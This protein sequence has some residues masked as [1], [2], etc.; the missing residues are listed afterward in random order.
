MM[1][2]TAAAAR[3]TLSPLR[4]AEVARRSL[5][6]LFS[7]LDLGHSLAVMAEK[8]SRPAPPRVILTGRGSMA[9]SLAAAAA[10]RV[11]FPLHQPAASSANAA[12]DGQQQVQ[13]RGSPNAKGPLNVAKV[14][15]RRSL[16]LSVGR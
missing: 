4:P 1:M 10:G 2:S 5:K 12:R 16:V 15:Q 9:T 6:E 14:R 7:A 8:K 3:Q 13:Y 11:A